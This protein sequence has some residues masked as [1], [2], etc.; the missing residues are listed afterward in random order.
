MESE[1]DSDDDGGT[2]SSSDASQHL[3][4]ETIAEDDVKRVVT[5]TNV[6]GGTATQRSNIVALLRRISK[7]K[8]AFAFANIFQFANWIAYFRIFRS[9]K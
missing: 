9:E 1:V 2:V 4:A 6:A 8:F 5:V 3:P 7:T